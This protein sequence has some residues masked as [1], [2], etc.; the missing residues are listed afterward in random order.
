MKIRNKFSLLGIVLV[1]VPLVTVTYFQHSSMTQ[2]GRN[3]A[4]QTKTT[5]IQKEQALL[6]KIVQD[7]TAILQR[8]KETHERALQLQA[9]DV[10]RILAQQ[11]PA[12]W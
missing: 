12:S 7:Y 11:P 6:H 3:M 4:E 10:E 1:V 2:F 5:L 8:D 9:R